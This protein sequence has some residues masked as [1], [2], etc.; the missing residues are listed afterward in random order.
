[1]PG[2]GGVYFKNMDLDR[3]VGSV[4]DFDYF[5]FTTETRTYDLCVYRAPLFALLCKDCG[6]LVC[7]DT[8]MY[9]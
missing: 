7:L 6:T 2:G 9:N 5:D 3:C 8:I 4:S 1:M